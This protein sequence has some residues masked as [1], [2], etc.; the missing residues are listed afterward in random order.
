MSSFSEAKY[1]DMPGVYEGASIVVLPSLYEGL[2]LVLM[3]AIACERPM[4]ATPVGAAPKL[5]SEVYEKNDGKFI[6]ENES[7][8]ARKMAAILRDKKGYAQICQRARAKLIKK[9]SWKEVA[10]RTL[11]VYKSAVGGA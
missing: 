6:F 5:F 11:E 2:S 3:E 8:L 1:T 7:E 9:Y 4:L 10:K